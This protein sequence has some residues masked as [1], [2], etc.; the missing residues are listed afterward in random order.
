MPHLRTV[1]LLEMITCSTGLKRPSFLYK[2]GA[3]VHYMLTRNL[4]VCLGA[5]RATSQVLVLTEF[6]DI[7]VHALT[8]HQ[9][10]PAF[11]SIRNV[12]SSTFTLRSVFEVIRC[13]VAQYSRY[14]FELTFSAMISGS[15]NEAWTLGP[16]RSLSLARMFLDL[17]QQQAL[18]RLRPNN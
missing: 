16:W 4:S 9:N 7:P 5:P 2:V 17:L 14:K 18:G 12:A 3:S 11:L 13:V 8:T 15:L 10:T 1:A 6:R